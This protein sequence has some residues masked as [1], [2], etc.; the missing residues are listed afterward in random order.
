LVGLLGSAFPLS[1]TKTQALLHKVL[2]V[3]ISRGAIVAIRQRLR[4]VLDRLMAEAIQAAQ[5]QPVA[6]VDETGAPTG[7]ADG[8]NP[9]CKRVWLW[10]MVTPMVTVFLQGLSRS[11]A[12]AIE[13]LRPGFDGIVVSDRFSAYNHLDSNQRQ[14]CWAHLIR[15]FNAMAEHQGASAEI[16]AELQRLQRQL[17][18]RWHP[19]KGNL[20]AWHELQRQCQ[21]IRQVFEQVLQHVDDLG[22]QRS[23]TTP[24]EK[25]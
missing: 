13:L 15:D 20:I 1:V 22:F 23:E 4:A 24:W 17:L 8:N 9:D 11:T 7:N 6:Y 5:Q 3:E 2:G 19:W 18:E 12:A 21:P 16:G 10:V 25:Q 14:L